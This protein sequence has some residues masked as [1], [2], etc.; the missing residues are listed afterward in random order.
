MASGK[1]YP[2]AGHSFLAVLRSPFDP[3]KGVAVFFGYDVESVSEAGRKLVH[4]GKYG[5]LAF[6]GGKNV[7]KGS[8]ELKDSPLTYRFDGR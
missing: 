7:G 8:W 1:S 5:Y 3:G 4:Y 6:E 2:V